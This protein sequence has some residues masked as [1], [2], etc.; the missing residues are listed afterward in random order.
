MN[1]RLNRGSLT[2][3]VVFVIV[4]LAFLLESLDIW[5]IAPEVLWPSLLIAVGG[6]LLIGGPGKRGPDD[7]DEQGR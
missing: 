3:G 2:A 7:V 1:D 6:T 4:G 5:Q